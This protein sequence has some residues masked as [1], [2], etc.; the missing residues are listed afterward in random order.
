MDDGQVRLMGDIL[1]FDAQTALRKLN[2]KSFDFS[3]LTEELKKIRFQFIDQIPPEFDTNEL[4]LL[5]LRSKW[6][7]ETETGQFTVCIR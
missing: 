3:N 4:F 5:A 1:M 6:L 2:G 7:K